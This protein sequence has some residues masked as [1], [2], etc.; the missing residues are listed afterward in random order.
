M[1]LGVPGQIIQ[2]NGKTALTDFWGTRK[3]VKLDG[4]SEPVVPGD[5]I[6]N[7]AGSAVR[8]IDPELV[9]ETMALYEVLLCEAGEDPLATDIVD[10]L[11]EAETLELVG[12]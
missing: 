5:Y 3:N 10:E 7:H 12:A 11:E 6:L 1:C 9:A 4:L 2:I 8:K